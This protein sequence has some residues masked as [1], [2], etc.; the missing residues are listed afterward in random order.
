MAKKNESKN[1]LDFIPMKSEKIQYK[2]EEDGNIQLIVPRT[3]FFDKI[4]IK[5][6]F[7]PDK[8]KI[9]LDDMGSF[10]WNSIDGKRNVYEIGKLVK[11]KFGEDAEPLYERLVEYLN[12]LRNNKFIKFVDE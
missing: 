1:Y 6:F 10:I 11:E 3:S 12:I 9:D 8:F 5:L 7:A 4:A 2:E